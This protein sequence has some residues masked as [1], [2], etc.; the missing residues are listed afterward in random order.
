MMSGK[1][2]ARNV[3]LTD[4]VHDGDRTRTP[5]AGGADVLP[6]IIRTVGL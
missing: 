6:L 2:K 3:G 4:D 5:P 1:A